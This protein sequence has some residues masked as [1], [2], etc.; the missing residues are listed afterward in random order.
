MDEEDERMLAVKNGD[1]GEGKLKKYDPFKTEVSS[2][3][4]TLDVSS[5]VPVE[6]AKQS[7]ASS[8]SSLEPLSLAPNPVQHIKRDVS[9]PT[10]VKTPPSSSVF[11]QSP[12]H[13]VSRGVRTKGAESFVPSDQDLSIE[14]VFLYSCLKQCIE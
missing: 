5:L 6:A 11:D 1:S 10:G 12:P 13:M 9:P 7:C 3:D 4:G 2:A 8:S 14:N